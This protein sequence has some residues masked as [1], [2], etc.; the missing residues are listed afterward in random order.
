MRADPASSLFERRFGLRKLSTM[1][2]SSL[3]G[4]SEEELSGMS[5][6]ELAALAPIV[7]EDSDAG[8]EIDRESV[9]E[10]QNE[11]LQFGHCSTIR[12]VSR[13]NQ[14]GD[15]ERRDARREHQ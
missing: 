7:T 4:A 14:I 6:L 3:H 9:A 10:N 12:T 1:A 13:A 11:A 5:E 2:K 15:C 8:G